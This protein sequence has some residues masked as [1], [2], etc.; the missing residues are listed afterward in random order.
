MKYNHRI[1]QWAGWGREDETG[2]WY[3][4]P[5]I[6]RMS[7]PPL[8]DEARSLWDGVLFSLLEERGLRHDFIVAG[9]WW[10][11]DIAATNEWALLTA[12]PAQ[13]T[14]ALMRVIDEEK[15]EA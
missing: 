5:G 8:I 12:T 4:V 15:E 1:A 6:G 7:H 11:E 3:S 14:E 9:S 13:L 2:A 10:M